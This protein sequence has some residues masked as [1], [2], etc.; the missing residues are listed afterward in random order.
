MGFFSPKTRKANKI[1]N[2]TA[3]REQKVLFTRSWL[4]LIDTGRVFSRSTAFTLFGVLTLIGAAQLYAQTE[5]ELPRKLDTVFVFPGKIESETWDQ[6]GV[7]LLTEVTEEGL[8]QEFNKNNSLYI[9]ED[10]ASTNEQAE[11][12]GEDSLDTIDTPLNDG[13]TEG[14]IIND[15]T[16]P[17][18]SGEELLEA[19]MIDSIDAAEVETPGGDSVI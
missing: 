2:S 18:V 4:T 16:D 11:T 10:A 14:G 5:I 17:P 12:P 15:V 8:Y 13:G 7:F 3:L 9:S 19:D 6:D 1:A